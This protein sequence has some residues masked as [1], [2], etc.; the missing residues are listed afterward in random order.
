M[1]HSQTGGL[2]QFGDTELFIDLGIL[3]SVAPGIHHYHLVTVG[4][5]LTDMLLVIP[6]G[7]ERRQSAFS[8]HSRHAGIQAH[9]VIAYGLFAGNADSSDGEFP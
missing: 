3:A 7:K 9:H 2:F 8:E 6:K 5:V 4:M 1:S